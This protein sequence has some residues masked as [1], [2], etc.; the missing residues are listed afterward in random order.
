V[1]VEVVLEV[2]IILPIAYDVVFARAMARITILLK[3]KD[4]SSFQPRLHYWLEDLVNTP[5][6]CNLSIGVAGNLC[7]RSVGTVFQLPGPDAIYS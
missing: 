3:Y 4:V 1:N 2:V 7:E 6:L 5:A